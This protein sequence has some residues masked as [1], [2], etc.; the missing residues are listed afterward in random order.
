MFPLR[1]G[2]LGLIDWDALR[3][4]MVSVG[5]V[6]AAAAAAAAARFHDDGENDLCYV[7]C[8]LLH[9]TRFGVLERLGKQ[10]EKLGT[11]GRAVR[12]GV[13]RRMEY[14]TTKKEGEGLQAEKRQP[15]RRYLV[16][17]EQGT[18]ASEWKAKKQKPI[19]ADTSFASRG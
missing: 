4:R 6:A 5:E 12:R 8:M 14:G 9:R 15:G 3:E 17:A 18:C 19:N 7:Q 11:R 13:E 10:G 1:Q 2:N 16:P